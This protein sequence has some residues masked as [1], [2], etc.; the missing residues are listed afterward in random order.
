V[1]DD[2]TAHVAADTFTGGKAMPSNFS[3]RIHPNSDNVHIRLLGDF[4]GAAACRLV[5]SIEKYK[6]YARKVFIYTNDL[7]NVHALGKETFRNTIDLPVDDVLK[8]VFAG[9]HA[10]EIA[11]YSFQII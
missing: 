7:Q 8:L 1:P 11:P 6:K 10:A 5:A 9:K 4:D 2:A 3:M